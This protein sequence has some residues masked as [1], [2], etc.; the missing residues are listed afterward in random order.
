MYVEVKE[1]YQVKI[2]SRFPALEDLDDDDDDDDYDDI[3]INEICE[4]FRIWKLQPQRV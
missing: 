1:Q 2:S 4:S 3:D